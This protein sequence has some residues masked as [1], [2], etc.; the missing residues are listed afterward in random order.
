VVH[1]LTTHDG[2]MFHARLKKAQPTE[3]FYSVGQRRYCD[4]LEAD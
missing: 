3:Q 4:L 1:E 2:K